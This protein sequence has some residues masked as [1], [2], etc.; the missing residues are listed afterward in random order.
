MV[1]CVVL[2]NANK[3]ISLSCTVQCEHRNNSSNSMIYFPTAFFR[4]FAFFSLSLKLMTSLKR[5]FVISKGKSF[6]KIVHSNYN[7]IK[8]SF[9][10]K[11]NWKYIIHFFPQ[12]R[13]F[14]S[15]SF[16]NYKPCGLLSVLLS[17]RALLYKI[18]HWFRPLRHPPPPPPQLLD[19]PG[20]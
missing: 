5:E 18:V 19:R 20:T 3:A 7:A 14:P 6:L 1:F 17:W 2:L 16:L 10:K 13:I 11:T 12:R 4:T 9:W 15:E 8:T